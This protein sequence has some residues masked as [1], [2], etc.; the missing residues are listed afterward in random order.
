MASVVRQP[1]VAGLSVHRNRYLPAAALA[2]ACVVAGYT[3]AGENGGPTLCP[4]R[5]FSGGAWCPGCGATRAVGSTVRGDLGAA[6]HL[7]PW[8]VLIL[9]QVTAGIAWFTRAPDAASAWWNQRAN[10]VLGA[11]VFVG[12]SLWIAR[13]SMGV[14]PHP[15]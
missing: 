1:R 7:N 12:L 6:F 10:L 2:G 14:I 15:F 9:V 4:Y 11:N 3:P 8:A 5:V 13:M